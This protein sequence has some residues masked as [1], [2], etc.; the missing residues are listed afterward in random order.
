MQTLALTQWILS[1]AL[2]PLVAGLIQW[3]KA[4]L[5]ARQG[6]SPLQPYRDAWKLVHRRATWPET[7]SLIFGL[8]PYLTFVT[9]VL[10]L[11]F[12]SYTV[13]PVDGGDVDLLTPIF[14]IALAKFGIGLA[15]LDSG[16]PLA[17]L[18]GSRTMFMHVLGEPTLVALAYA[19]LLQVGS[20]QA[21]P[22]V[23]SQS[24]LL[25]P[26]LLISA[27]LFGIILI[28]AGRLPF[29]NSETRLELT[30][31]EDAVALDYGGPELA[32]WEWARALRLTFF[33][34]LFVSIVVPV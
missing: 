28:E 26:P 10:L 19:Y 14:L 27:S 8:A 5:Q 18:G 6:P 25:L 17:A 21:G 7:A 11:G 33:F 15:A 2:A 3:I 34:T 16:T 32:A 29:E 1:V 12:L 24:L 31:I 20:A 4:R 30:M 13:T 9:Y 23:A 22:G